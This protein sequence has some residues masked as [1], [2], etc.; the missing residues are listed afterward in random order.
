[1]AQNVTIVPN[2][3]LEAIL[4]KLDSLEKIVSAVELQPRKTWLTIDE[5]AD[6]IGR[7]TR[8]IRRYIDAGQLETKQTAG[9]TLIKAP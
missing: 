3:T 1:M 7:S 5:Y 8:T 6:T 4:N 9:V 2:D